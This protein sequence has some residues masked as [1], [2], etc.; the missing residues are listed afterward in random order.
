MDKSKREPVEPKKVVPFYA[1]KVKKG[2]TVKTNIR[3]GEQAV[4]QESKQKQ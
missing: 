3:A 1:K 2:L 4:K